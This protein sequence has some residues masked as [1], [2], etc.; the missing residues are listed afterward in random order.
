LNQPVVSGRALAKRVSKL[1]LD[2]GRAEEAVCILAAWAASGPNDREGQELLAEALRLDAGSELAKGAFMR[3]EGL[4]AEQPALDQAIRDYGPGALSR[5][6]SEHRRPVFHRAQVGFNNNV[7]YQGAVYHVQTE[8][9]GIDRP[10]IITH[11]FADG[12]RVLKSHKRSYASEVERSDV[13]AYVRGLMKAQ[14][15]EMCVLLREG[16]FDAIIAGKAAGGL[17]VLEEVP[18]VRIRRGA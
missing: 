17:S 15:L 16:R 7:K 6:E 12:G 2:K 4:P 3:M 5:L 13:A 9:S 10:H 11:L 18:G 8:D 1:L 14:H